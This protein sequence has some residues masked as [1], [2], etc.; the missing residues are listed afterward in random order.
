MRL[1]RKFRRLFLYLHLVLGR[2]WNVLEKVQLALLLRTRILDVDKLR[3]RNSRCLADDA[4]ILVVLARWLV[5][6]AHGGVDAE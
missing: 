4:R 2:Q 3:V 5:V 1:T 6:D